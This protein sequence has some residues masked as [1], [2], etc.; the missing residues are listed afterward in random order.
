LFLVAASIASLDIASAGVVYDDFTPKWRKF[1]VGSGTVLKMLR[2][3]A[4][5]TLAADAEGTGA[6]FF[7]RGLTSTCVVSGNFDLRVS[8]RLLNWPNGNG[9]RA[10]LFLGDPAQIDDETQGLFIERD[11]YSTA[12]GGP[13]EVYVFF[14]GGDIVQEVDAA[15]T[16]GQ[17]RV[18]RDG[19]IVTGYYRHGA[20]WVSLSSIDLGTP[21]DLQFTILL[22]SHDSV[23]ADMRASAA[24][25]NFNVVTGALKGEACPY[26]A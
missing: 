8:Y 20:S 7:S 14:A 6:D 2:N 15:H 13:R 17:L 22:Y 19:S 26:A 18:V 10:A 12:D 1:Q 4:E 23:F 5:I 16:L 9:V 25:D 21:E 11:S 3:R 24:F